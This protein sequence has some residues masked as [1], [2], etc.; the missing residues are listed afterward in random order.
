MAQLMSDPR[1]DDGSRDDNSGDGIEPDAL[2]AFSED[3]LG[4][5]GDLRGKR[6][7]HVTFGCVDESV[8]LAKLDARVTVVGDEGE[9]PVLAAREGVSGATEFVDDDAGALSFD[10]RTGRTFDL[11]YSGFGA[12]GWVPSLADWAS[13]IAAVLEAGGRLVVY[14][15]H[16]FAFTAGP[17]DTGGLAI[18]SSYFGSGPDDMGGESDL[19][20][21]GEHPDERGA[22]A[23]AAGSLADALA[24]DDAAADAEAEEESGDWTLGDLVGALGGAGLAVIDLQ[25][26]RTSERYETAL[27]VLGDEVDE[28]VLDCVPSAM[29]LV[30]VKLPEGLMG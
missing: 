19:E 5:L 11:V 10:F 3:E 24:S 4:A 1:K 12:L 25:E 28:D 6:V 22:Q 20:S 23:A 14:D 7:L 29:L 21:E 18:T 13:G 15:E 9:G 16:P 27:D 2:M 17:D 30:A 8:M 26:F